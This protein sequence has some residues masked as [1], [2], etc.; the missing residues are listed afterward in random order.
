MQHPGDDHVALGTISFVPL[1]HDDRALV[2]GWLEAEHVAR[3]WAPTPEALAE[4]ESEMAEMIDRTDPGEIFVVHVD[5]TAVGLIQRYRMVDD[6]EWAA[7]LSVAADPTGAAGI[8]FLIGEPQRVQ[9][10]IGTAMIGAFVDEVF[11]R[12]PDVTQILVDPQVENRP[13]WRA[14]ERN[15][16]ERI[17]TGHIEDDDPA[18]VGPCHVYRLRRPSAD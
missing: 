4:V 2:H 3:W 7:A 12:Y 9:R 14:L 16:F 1:T 17:W 18:N 10:G 15:G 8:D 13:S 5:G 6:V 11:A